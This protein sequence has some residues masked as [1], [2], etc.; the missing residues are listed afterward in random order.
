[1][2]NQFMRAFQKKPAATAHV[3]KER[4][5]I[6]VSHQRLN[7]SGP[8]YLPLMRKDLLDVIAKY[9]PAVNREDVQVDIERTKSTATLALN[10]TLKDTII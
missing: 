9:I 10:I 3:A 1:M 4:L 2:L 8:D 6:V 7:R 5:Q